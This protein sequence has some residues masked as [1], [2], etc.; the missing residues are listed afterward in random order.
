MLPLQPIPPTPA[1]VGLQVLDRTPVRPL[2]PLALVRLPG[3]P[4]RAA[5]AEFSHGGGDAILTPTSTPTLNLLRC[6][7]PVTTLDD[8]PAFFLP[9]PHSRWQSGVGTRF[10]ALRTLN[11]S[12]S[13]FSATWRGHTVH[14]VPEAITPAAGTRTERPAGRTRLNTAV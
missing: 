12:H 14:T 4:D 9:S 2:S 13:F 6:F 5:V 7:S 11:T 10:L 1:D 3:E 8:P